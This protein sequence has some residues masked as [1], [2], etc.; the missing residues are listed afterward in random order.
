MQFIFTSSS[1]ATFI[2]MVLCKQNLSFLFQGFE[3]WSFEIV[4]VVRTNIVADFWKYFQLCFLKDFEVG[5]LFIVKIFLCKQGFYLCWT[6]L[7]YQQRKTHLFD[8][9]PLT[10]EVA[11]I[12]KIQFCKTNNISDL[13]YIS[14]SYGL[15][16][17]ILGFW[18]RWQIH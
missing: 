13:L 10:I 12:W 3:V 18:N 2:F 15:S 14:V 6:C 16:Y 1:S 11:A 17:C 7:K 5:H 8:H 4:Q 9:F